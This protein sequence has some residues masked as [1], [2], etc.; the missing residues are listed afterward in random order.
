MTG[1]QALVALALFAPGV[2]GPQLGYGEGAISLFATACF[3]VGVA[4]SLYGGLLAARLGSFMVAA[5]CALAIA[6]AMAVASIG[7]LAA[8]VASGLIVGLA[9]GPETPASSTLLARLARPEQRPLISP[10][11]RPATRSAP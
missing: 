4:T 3:A 8:L 10:C 1:L 2:L 6:I 7:T 11:A 9:F 5:L